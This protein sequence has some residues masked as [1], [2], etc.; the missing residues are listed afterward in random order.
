M[1]DLGHIFLKQSFDILATQTFKDFD[2]VIS[3]HSQN[4]AIE[5]LCTM[6]NNKL[7]IH[8]YR[9]TEHCGSSSA[10]INNAIKKATGKL[11]KVL[12]QDDFLFHEK[13][14]E[15]IV[16][17]FDMQKDHWLITACIHSVNGTDFFKPFYPA[18]NNKIRW[19][20]NTIS[21]PS[22]LTIKND[23]PILFDEKL[24]WLMDCDYYQRCYDAFGK[25]I[26]LNDINVVN[27][28]GEHQ[29]SHTLVHLSTRIKEYIHTWKKYVS[30]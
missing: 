12:F 25:P 10:N 16:T 5:D 27:R 24:I 15:E 19:G 6:Y 20:I 7:F 18:Y 2:I 28:T 1:K 23:T 26:I 3:D 4:T 14:L 13:A 9:N 11:I 29:V 17:H 21:S 30:N 8:Y 22:V